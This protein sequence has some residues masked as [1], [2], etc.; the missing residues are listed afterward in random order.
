M[1]LVES[2]YAPQISIEAIGG[3]QRTPL[4]I[5]TTVIP[6]GYFI[7]D[8]REAHPATRAEM[9]A[10]R[11]RAARR[12]GPGSPG[13][14][15]RRERRFHRRSSEARSSR[16]VAPTLRWA[17]RAVALSAARQ[18]VTT[19]ETVQDAAQSRRDNG[20]ATVVSLAQAQRQT[21]QARFNLAKASGDERNAYANL[22]A[23]IGLDADTRIDIADSSEQPLPAEPPEHIDAAAARRVDESAG[24]HRGARQDRG[25][26]RAP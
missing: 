8:T 11:L 17:P 14:F 5:P 3:F 26:A 10:V 7:S 15:V 6:K 22:I 13:Q 9:A 12:A 19:A 25:R 18:A 16:S 1:G 20:L 23:S 2:S 24:C 4:P 21:A